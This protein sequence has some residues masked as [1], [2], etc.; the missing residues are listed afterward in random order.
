MKV[1]ELLYNKSEEWTSCK[2]SKSVKNAL[3]ANAA[4]VLDLTL[5]RES[6]A[7]STDRLEHEPW[8]L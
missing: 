7:G 4:T 2:C 1:A 5:A 8:L 6:T 3:H